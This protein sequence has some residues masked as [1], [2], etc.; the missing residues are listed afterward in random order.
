MID[1]TKGRKTTSI[2]PSCCYPSRVLLS[3]GASFRAALV[4]RGFTT[5]SQFDGV[6]ERVDH[7]LPT[8]SC[9]LECSRRTTNRFA[10]RQGPHDEG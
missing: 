7:A 8:S 9:K 3:A 6:A 10:L 2:I 4:T 5:S 1:F